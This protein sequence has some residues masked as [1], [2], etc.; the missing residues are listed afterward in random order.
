LTAS[1]IQ[2]ICVN[3]RVGVKVTSMLLFTISIQEVGSKISRS[4]TKILMI[5]W[6]KTSHC[7]VRQWMMRS[8]LQSDG[9]NLEWMLRWGRQ[10]NIWSILFR[11]GWRR[12]YKGRY[13][14]FQENVKRLY[15][16]TLFEDVTKWENEIIWSLVCNFQFGKIHQY[17]MM[18]RL[19]GNANAMQSWPKLYAN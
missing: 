17:C 15:T 2:I 14:L 6:Y 16:S 19:Q 10:W 5:L 12:L 7:I 1:I 4:I 13:R 11:N 9:S 8:S 3:S 18:T